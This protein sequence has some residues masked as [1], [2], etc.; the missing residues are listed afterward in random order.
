M[1]CCPRIRHQQRELEQH[2]NG[3]CSAFLCGLFSSKTLTPYTP[4]CLACAII[5]QNAELNE[6][7]GGIFIF[8]S[9]IFI[10]WRLITL[11]YC[12]GFCHTL[13]WIS[14]GFTRV[15]HPDP[16][17][18]PPSPSHP[19]G[20]SQCTTQMYRTDIWTL[21]E[22]ARVGWSER[23]AL[24]HVYY[25]V[26]NRSPVQAGGIFKLKQ[27]LHIIQSLQVH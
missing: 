17:L 16:P 13:T 25:Q 18:P 21:W 4:P 15:P 24:K 12:N 5:N 3:V 2:N 7:L 1:E 23:I 19:S 6:E 9:F 20:S 26:W 10:S 22:K 8:F 27:Y 11:Q 14:H